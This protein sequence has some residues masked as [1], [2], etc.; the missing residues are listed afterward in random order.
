MINIKLWKNEW[1]YWRALNMTEQQ[2][3]TE[4]Q[5]TIASLKNTIGTQAV[6]NA[7]MIAE[8][9]SIIQSIGTELEALKE[10]SKGTETELEQLRN[11][12]KKRDGKLNK[13]K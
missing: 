9:D 5:K 2:Q 6:S 8:R 3:I 1:N 7:T 12:L 13:N 4:L 11:E 10:S